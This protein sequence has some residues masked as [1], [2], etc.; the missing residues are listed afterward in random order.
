MAA[1]LS[2]V[3]FSA[4]IRRSHYFRRFVWLLVGTLT[5]AGAY[6]ALQAAASRAVAHPLLLDVGKA[7]AILLGGLL[8]VRGLYNLILTFV[9]RSESLQVY[10]KG[11]LWT[12]GG[13]TYKYRW[14]QL[15]RFR[16]GARGIYLF[17]RPLLRWGTHRLEMDDERVFK[18]GGVHGNTR[19]FA[20]VVRP[21]AAYVTSVKM[22][23]AL[24]ADRPVRLHP[25]L[26]LYPGGVEAGKTEIHWS[27]VNAAVKNG[28]LL[29]RRSQEKR[30]R[31]IRRYGLHRVDNVG[32]FLE[33][34]SSTR[35]QFLSARSAKQRAA[36]S[37]PS[38]GA[39]PGSSLAG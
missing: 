1:Q 18:F 12:R 22:S 38:K 19:R 17:R 29:L 25:R 39:L 37:R 36:A 6:A 26:T 23:R 30:A 7:A 13:K 27:E 21:Y 4:E 9:R 32:G 33:I 14:T 24:R 8:A 20:H 28:R 10:S 34:V 3:L 11:F 16:E 15:A 5:T 31:T 2:R 35:R